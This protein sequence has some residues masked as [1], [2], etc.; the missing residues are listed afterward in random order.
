MRVGDEQKLGGSLA[1]KIKLGGGASCDQNTHSRAARVRMRGDSA[2]VTDLGHG[3]A[4]ARLQLQLL[5]AI[6]CNTDRY[7]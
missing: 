6:V 1:F 4:Q 2:R 3:A 7:L 5:F